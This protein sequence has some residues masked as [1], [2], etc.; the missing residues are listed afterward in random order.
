MAEIDD[1]KNI[2][3]IGAGT[4]GPG[5]A[6]A[7]AHRGYEVKLVDIN[8]KHLS[9]ARSLMR[10]SLSTLVEFGAFKKEEVAPTLD[11]IFLTKSLEE[12]ASNAHLILETIVEDVDSKKKL[13]H[14][15]DQ[16]CPAETILTSNT[17]SLNIFSLVPRP[18]LPQ[19]VIAHWFAPPHII[20]LVEVVRGA[21]TTAH[22]MNLISGLLAKIGKVPVRIEKFIPGFVINRLL[23][24]LG[25]ETFFLLDNGYI[26]PEQLDLAA[27]MCLA[28]RMMTLGVV[29]RYD[30]TGL[31][32][33]VANLRNP[34]FFDPPIDHRPDS[35][36]D[37]VEKGHLGVKTGKGFFDYSGRSLEEILK[38]RDMNLL[39]TFE[40]T[41][42]GFKK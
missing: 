30:F 10:T 35:L 9:K 25:R 34:D 4:M 16:I 33:S 7:F 27:K 6:L 1:M 12:A 36:F 31:D 14:L 26:T 42:Y 38:E 39:R 40:N 13:F 19:T 15:L 21:E 8:E 41:E 18:R 28:P 22:T 11:R 17:S 5:I 37:L 2:G 20:P 23:R 3:V 29:Q 24:S 32:I